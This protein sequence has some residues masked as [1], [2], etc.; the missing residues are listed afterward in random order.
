MAVSGGLLTAVV[1]AVTAMRAASRLDRLHVRT[2]AAWV[3]LDA[4]LRRRAGVVRALPGD[5]AL[6]HAADVALRAGPAQREEAENELGRLLGAL[7]GQ[8]LPPAVVTQLADVE[9]RVML[10][11]RVYNDAVRDT[12]ALRSRRMVRWFRLAG[13][14]PMPRYFE[15][16]ESPLAA[17]ELE[18]DGVGA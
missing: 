16:V 13:T 3:A 4:A 14:A 18:L 2:D 5:A 17:Y 11:R 7:H 10:A 1:T 15:I 6:R 8:A 12:L 9:Q